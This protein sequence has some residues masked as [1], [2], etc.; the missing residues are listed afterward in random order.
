MAVGTAPRESHPPAVCRALPIA[1][2]ASNAR[3]VAVREY[4]S[5]CV[6]SP[7][8]SHAHFPVQVWDR[9]LQQRSWRTSRPARHRRDVSV[10]LMLRRNYPPGFLCQ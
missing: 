2:D 9:S 3:T 7:M 6:S 8:S 5:F 10:C 1:C 4:L